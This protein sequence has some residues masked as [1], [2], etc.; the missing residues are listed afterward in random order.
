V[1]WPKLFL[2]WGSSGLNFS[3]NVSP[4]QHRSKIWSLLHALASLRLTLFGLALLLAC[5]F[6]T[7]QG[8]LSTTVLLVGPLTL[9][10]M[11]LA[12]TIA[13]N[14]KL[15]HQPG[16][17]IF[18]LC[19][20]A[21]ILLAA[22][23]R[24]TYL[25]G[26][27]EVTEGM[28]FTN[29]FTMLEAGPWH[30]GNLNDVRFINESFHIDY[31]PAVTIART[32]N[33]VRFPD[34]SGQWRESLITEQKPLEL[35]GYRFYVTSNKGFAPVFTWFPADG[36]MPQSGAIHLPRYPTNKFAQAMEWSIPGTGIM[37]WLQLVLDEPVLEEGEASRLQ[38]PRLYHA[39]IRKGDM[40][41]VL[42][43]GERL[44]L[45][46]GELELTELRMWMGYSVF[47]DWTIPWMLAAG[48]LAVL[49]LGWHFWR[50][51]MAKPWDM[52]DR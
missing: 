52:T 10:A 49:S 24:M 34:A 5:A 45:P 18:H 38:P 27:V 21:V 1:Y 37:L 13:S 11:N 22:M 33:R 32:E 14:R 4:D 48:T 12:A 26:G 47:Y 43:P 25:K 35:H 16:L 41:K 39:V 23:S 36:S 20:L 29:E 44:V 42:N 31:S 15:R 50:K 9:L 8:W 30:M 19:L 17:L 40:R 6:A 46:Q 51:F 3:G 7:L 28:E 2:S